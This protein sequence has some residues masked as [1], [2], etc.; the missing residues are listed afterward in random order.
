MK[1]TLGALLYMSEPLEGMCINHS[2]IKIARWGVGRTF[3]VSKEH[4]SAACKNVLGFKR[5]GHSRTHPCQLSPGGSCL[6]SKIV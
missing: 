6:M 1:G 4:T 2:F 3:W 5:V